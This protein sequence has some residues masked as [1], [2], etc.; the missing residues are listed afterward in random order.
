M[1]KLNQITLWEDD[2]PEEV[3]EKI[4]LALIELGVSVKQ[5]ETGRDGDFVTKTY[6]F[7]LADILPENT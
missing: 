5:T 7:K 2:L 4:T 1:N 6:E 3:V